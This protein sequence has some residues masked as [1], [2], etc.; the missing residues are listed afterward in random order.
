MTGLPQDGDGVS[1]RS[2]SHDVMVSQ[3]GPVT[4]V[5]RRMSLGWSF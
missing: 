2:M 1:I 3:S 4:S 5:W